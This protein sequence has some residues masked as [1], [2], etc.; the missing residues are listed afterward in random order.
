MIEG[1]LVLVLVLV[2]VLR[3][4]PEFSATLPAR[5][6]LTAIPFKVFGRIR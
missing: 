4:Y 6:A 1:L 5:S 3:D 2:L